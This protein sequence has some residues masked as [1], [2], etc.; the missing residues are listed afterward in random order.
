LLDDT[1]W[2][3]SM[4]T[5]PESG[6]PTT[7]YAIHPQTAEFLEALKERTDKTDKTLAEGTFVGF[8]GTLP[9]DSQKK[10]SGDRERIVI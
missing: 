9:E 7:H 1:G 8:V 4:Q 6:R 5:K 2:V 3:L 10:S